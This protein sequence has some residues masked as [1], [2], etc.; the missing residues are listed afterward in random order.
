MTT[1]SPE[2]SPWEVPPPILFNPWKHHAAALRYRI[3][4]AA[5]VGDAALKELSSQ[6]V[7]MGTELMDLYTGALSPAAIAA[8][9][10]ASLQADNLLQPQPYRT[11]VEANGGYRTLT[12]AEDNSCWVLRGSDEAERFVHLHPGRWTP[13]T[14]RVRA[15]V[16]KSAVMVLAYC[17]V[18]GGDPLDVGLVNKVRGLYLDLSPLKELPSGLGLAVVI[19]LLRSQPE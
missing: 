15:T 3:G 4:E 16:L 13:E 2:A 8:R 11:W 19:D 5:R 1:S 10:V 17:G 7:V 12:F 9:L 6:L 18:H 14:R